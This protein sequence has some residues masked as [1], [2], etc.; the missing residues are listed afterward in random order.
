MQARHGATIIMDET[1]TQLFVDPVQEA[2]KHIEA[3]TTLDD[4]ADS[5]RLDRDDRDTESFLFSAAA[6][7][8]Y[9]PNGGGK[10]ANFERNNEVEWYRRMRQPGVFFK[11]LRMTESSFDVLYNQVKLFMRYPGNGRVGHP[12]KI[13]LRIRL[14]LVL[15]RLAQGGCLLLTCDTADFSESTFN[16]VLREVL[17][18]IECALPTPMFPSSVDG[19]SN[20][21][22]DFVNLLGCLLRKVTGVIDGFLIPIRTPTARMK[23]SYSCRKCL[24]PLYLLAITDSRKRFLWTH[25]GLPGSIGD[26]RAFQESRFN[27]KNKFSTPVLYA[28]FSLLAD[29]GFASKKWLL[30]PY[31]RDQRNEKRRYV[32]YVLSSAR[33]IVENAFGVLEGRWRILHHGICTDV[34]TA[35]QVCDVCV[36]LHRFL[37]E[38]GDSWTDNV[39]VRDTDP[40]VTAEDMT[41][42]GDDAD[43]L[44]LRIELCEALWA[45]YH[46]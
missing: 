23:V 26:S 40:D 19:Q 44:R 45:S 15:Y 39:D 12:P 33:V 10:R 13:H 11:R 38:R 29:G 28:G 21:A 2:E 46:C 25:S 4:V 32:N 9:H 5:S 35:R 20:V 24:Y 18:A 3:S 16:R 27:R 31:P 43:S 34:E 8:F 36:L 6:T 7:L 14:L 37:I 1:E 42:D 41:S 17:S 22:V 30:K